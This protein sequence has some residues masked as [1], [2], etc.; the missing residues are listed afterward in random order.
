MAPHRPANIRSIRPPTGHR[1]RSTV[2]PVAARTDWEDEAI[3]WVR[4][5]RTE[6]HDAYWTYRR[7]FFDAIVPA[8]GARTLDMGCGE[9]RVSRDLRD[10]GHRTVGVDLSP[11][12]VRHA[13]DADPT[14]IYLRAD[15]SALPLADASCDLVV[16]YNTLMDIDG[17]EAAVAEASRVLVSGG[18]F[19]ICVT[20]PMSN[21][22]RFDGQAS[23]ATFVVATTY[24]GRR[25]FEA[26]EARDGL[27]MTFRG[28]SYA[29]EDYARA[30]EGA[31]FLVEMIREPVPDTTTPNLLRWSRVPL[32]LHI[33]AVRP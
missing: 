3:S 21:T 6:G 15:A 28:W 25:R 13:R 32:F 4:W 5:A 29:L 11:T 23:D 22:G 1:R 16:A 19:C 12:L 26:T 14:G 30:L 10:R 27:T 31:G 20:H 2:G 7:P 33:R 18:R 17:M 9:G 8:P 24:F